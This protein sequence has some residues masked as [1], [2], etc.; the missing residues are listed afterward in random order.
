MKLITSNTDTHLDD[1]PTLQN[2]T[3]QENKITTEVVIIIEGRCIL[4]MIMQ[5]YLRRII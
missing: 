3:P 5:I 4:R 1:R 2:D